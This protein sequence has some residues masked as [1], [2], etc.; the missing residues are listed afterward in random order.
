MYPIGIQFFP[1]TKF[2][3]YRSKSESVTDHDAVEV[4]VPLEELEVAFEI[5]TF[6]SSDTCTDFWGLTLLLLLE[7]APTIDAPTKPVVALRWDRFFSL[8]FHVPE[9]SKWLPDPCWDESYTSR[10]L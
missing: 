5:E 4:V 10:V 7:P 9:T 1:S 2:Q 6:L 3:L 8:K